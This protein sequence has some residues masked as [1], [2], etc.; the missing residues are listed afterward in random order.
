MSGFYFTQ[1]FLTATLQ[2]YARKYQIPID[3]L[4]FD[5]EFLEEPSVEIIEEQG[6]RLEQDDGQLMHGLF[7]EG[8]KWDYVNKVLAE[9]DPKILHVKAPIIRLKPI[10]IQDL[11]H[12]PH[13]KCPVYKTSERRGVLSTTGHSTNFII[14]V[15]MNSDRSEAHW[16]KRG[17]AM[18]CQ[19]SE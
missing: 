10:L 16:V 3:T 12:H 7:I 19:L 4:T 18:L 1:T 8:C 5:F 15:N 14:Y 2:N 9:S 11:Q 13:Y 17:V 6:L